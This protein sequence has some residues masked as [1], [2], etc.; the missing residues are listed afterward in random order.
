MY[1]IFVTWITYKGLAV[2][3]PQKKELSNFSYHGIRERRTLQA[4]RTLGDSSVQQSHL[5]KKFREA[6]YD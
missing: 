6:S 5:Q 2:T 1:F 3:Y 4:V